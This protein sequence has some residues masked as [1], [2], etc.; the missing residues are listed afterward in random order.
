MVLDRGSS[1]HFNWKE[2]VMF[3]YFGMF[4]GAIL[5]GVFITLFEA[6]HFEF[7]PALGLTVLVVFGINLTAMS[8]AR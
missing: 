3:R 7:W 5:G 6:A 2:I 4:G 1:W 8:F